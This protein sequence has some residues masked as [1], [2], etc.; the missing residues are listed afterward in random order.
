MEEIEI[1]SWLTLDALKKKAD[2]AETVGNLQTGHSMSVFCQ[3]EDDYLELV[4]TDATA[5]SLRRYEDKDEFESAIEQRKEEDGEAAYD[6]DREC[7]E[8]E[9][10]DKDEDDVLEADAEDDDY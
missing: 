7:E 2:L 10:D 3:I 8:D 9:D 6:E 4:Y 5:N 1:S